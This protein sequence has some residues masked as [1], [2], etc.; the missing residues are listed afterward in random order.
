MWLQSNIA[1][2][3]I[4]TTRSFDHVRPS[5]R[6]LLRNI[7]RGGQSTCGEDEEGGADWS[8]RN[9]SCSVFSLDVFSMLRCDLNSLNVAEM[10]VDWRKQMYKWHARIVNIWI[11]VLYIVLEGSFQ[12]HFSLDDWM[13]SK[14]NTSTFSCFMLNVIENTV[15]NGTFYP[16]FRVRRLTLSLL[17]QVVTESSTSRQHKGS[18]CW[19]RRAEWEKWQ[20]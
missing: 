2:T 12:T 16:V 9:T 10:K 17:T 13:H 4:W 6:N 5:P 19:G 15:A 11:A 20:I 1:Q 18:G 3:F 8:S 7:S 14:N